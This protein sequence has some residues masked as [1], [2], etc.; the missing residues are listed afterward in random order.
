MSIEEH[1]LRKSRGV[2]LSIKH[3]LTGFIL[4]QTKIFSFN[5]SENL[6]C[7]GRNTKK[8]NKKIQFLKITSLTKI[9]TFFF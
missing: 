6:D 4:Y 2:N 7:F 3:M 8:S 1:P 5:I 9:I